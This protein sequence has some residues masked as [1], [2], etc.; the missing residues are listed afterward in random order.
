M[1]QEP[2]SNPQSA[3]TGREAA[4]E[5]SPVSPRKVLTAV[6][7]ILLI[8]IVLAAVGILR[9]MHAGSVLAERTDALAA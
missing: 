3:A 8:L 7:V 6:A 9:R 2:N 5:Q 4:P 1:T